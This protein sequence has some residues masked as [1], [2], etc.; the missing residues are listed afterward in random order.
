MAM[1]FGPPLAGAKDPASDIHQD[2]DGVNLATD[3]WFAPSNPGPR[4]SPRPRNPLC[5]RH[6]DAP[7]T[8]IEAVLGAL[9]GHRAPAAEA[10]DRPVVGPV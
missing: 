4:A 3:D 1:L 6:R 2:L 7:A 8:G 10:A 5:P 9:S